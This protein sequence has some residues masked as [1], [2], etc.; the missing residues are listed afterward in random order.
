MRELLL[1][2]SNPHK[3]EEI[4]QVLDGL[5]QVKGLREI[6]F[7]EEIPETGATLRENAQIKA[8]FLHE[9]TGM[10]C[11]SEDTGLEVDALSGAPGV[12]TARYAGEQRSPEANMARLLSALEG[13]SDRRARFRTVVALIWEGQTHFFEGVA[14]GHIATERLGSGGFGYDPVFVPEGESR[15]FAQMESHEKNAIS[16]RAKAVE[17]LVAF[18]RERP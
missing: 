1:A 9:K 17:K 16:H 13:R 8:L 7:E 10:N 12:H 5:W 18:L 11:F 4:R 3:I 15:S 2:S 14:E 6:G